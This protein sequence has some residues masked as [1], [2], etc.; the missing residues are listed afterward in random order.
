[1]KSQAR[2][3]LAKYEDPALYAASSA[4]RQAK[5][6]DW[7]MELMPARE[8][9]SCLDVGCGNGDFLNRLATSGKV[10]S[11]LM[12]VD[13]SADMVKAARNKL[14]GVAGNMRL[15]LRQADV[16]DLPDIKGKFDLITMMAVLHW[17]YPDEESVFAW[18]SDMLEEYGVFCL[19]TYHPSVNSRF[20][21]GSD[22]VALEALEQIGASTNFPRGF[23]PIGQRTRPVAELE[24]ALRSAFR[25][26]EV[27][28]RPAITRAASAQQYADFHVATF[29]SYYS[30]LIPSRARASFLEALGYSAMRRMR[31]LGYVT[32]MQVRFWICGRT[33]RSSGGAA[34]STREVLMTA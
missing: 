5:D 16:V 6:A 7:V 3:H 34:R 33:P 30:Q 15:N 1:M 13:R 12:G 11:S 26:Y 25:V 4:L 31:T 22:E 18:V 21:G 8:Y 10:T 27:H 19:T 14:R 28:A 29:G 9:R 17:I 32:R 24:L 23:T 20:V 2:F